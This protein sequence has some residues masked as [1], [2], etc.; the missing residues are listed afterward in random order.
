MQEK[1]SAV[2][3]Y[4]T[5]NDVSQ[6]PPELLRKGRFDEMFSVKFPNK[7]ERGEIFKIHLR[8]KKREALL[9]NGKISL[10]L[11]TNATSGFSGAEIEACITESL[12]SAFY[13]NRELVQTDILEAVRNTVPLSETMKERL[14][15]LEEWCKNRTRSASYSPEDDVTYGRTVEAN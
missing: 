14:G 3:V 10:E 7:M 2:F 15:R 13:E 8:K 5:S 11:L 6:L 12:Y 9:D 1:E 4:A